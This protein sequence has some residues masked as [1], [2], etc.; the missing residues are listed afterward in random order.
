MTK[1]PMT[2]KE[3]EARELANAIRDLPKMIDAVMAAYMSDGNSHSLPEIAQI[4]GAPLAMLRRVAR[5]L[6]N[7]WAPRDV[8][9]RFKGSMASEWEAPGYKQSP[10]EVW[11]PTLSEMRQRLLARDKQEG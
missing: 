2:E 1:T 8:Y 10:R 7:G 6:P 3:R 5:E 4:T 9:M 11:A